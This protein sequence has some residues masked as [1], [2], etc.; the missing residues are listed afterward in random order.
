MNISISAARIWELRIP[1]VIRYMNTNFLEDFFE[2][3]KI[4]LTTYER[5]RNHEDQIRRDTKEGR[6]SFNLTHGN[7]GVSGIH[8][9]GTHSYMLCGSIEESS[10]LMNHFCADNYLIINDIFGF[11]DA[12]SRYIPGFVNGK[13][14]SCVYKDDRL[15][16]TQTKIPTVPDHSRL[17]ASAQNGNSE[18]LE[19]EFHRMNNELYDNVAKELADTAYFVKEKYFAEELEFRIL[20]TTPY[21][22]L[23]PLHIKCPEAIRFCTY[24]KPLSRTITP[25]N[26][27]GDG[28][29]TILSGFT[30][31]PK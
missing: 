13:F 27:E 15:F 14:G 1:S 22:T 19:K 21:K 17:L 29:M 16:D 8:T 23:E 3:G 5:C 26:L 11:S 30:E 18:N 25:P 24:G 12:I 9:A 7:I 2:S 20:W 10:D 31:P 4:M 28:H 6:C